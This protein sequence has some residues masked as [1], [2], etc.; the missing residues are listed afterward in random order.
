VSRVVKSLANA[1]KFRTSCFTSSSDSDSEQKKLRLGVEVLVAT[2]GRLLALISRRE[3]SLADLQTIVL[4]EADVLFMDQ[5][6]PLKPIGDACPPSTQF[7][8][9]TATLPQVVIS[10]IR[11]EFPS[12]AYISG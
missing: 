7:I 9:T 1:L 10:Q 5:S 8:F 11:A 4:D 3:V 6:F 2:P 12:V